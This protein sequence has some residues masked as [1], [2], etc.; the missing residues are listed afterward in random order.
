MLALPKRRKNY[1]DTIKVV[2]GYLPGI[3]SMIPGTKGT[4]HELYR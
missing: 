1:H 4:D 3:V 2:R